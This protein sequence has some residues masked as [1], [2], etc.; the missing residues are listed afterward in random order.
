MKHTAL[1]GIWNNHLM[2]A[3][4]TVIAL[5]VSGCSISHTAEEPD[6]S[7]SEQTPENTGK[8]EE[9]ERMFYIHV[10]DSILT[11]SAEENSSADA[12]LELLKRNDLTIEMHDYGNFEKVGPLGTSLPRNDEQITT[13]AG[14]VILYQGNQITIYYDTNSWNFTRLGRI[15]DLSRKELKEILGSG[16]ITVT[17]S[18]DQKDRTA[19]K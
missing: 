14:D 5:M 8:S 12:F 7:A 10:N 4:L 2:I 9:S 11:V 19:A 6:S 13:E 16:E 17:F 3:V 15:Q 18:L 1:D